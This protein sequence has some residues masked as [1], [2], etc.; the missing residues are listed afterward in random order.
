MG[1][2]ATVDRVTAVIA[3]TLS[4][5]MPF[6]AMQFLPAAQRKSPY[7]AEALYRAMRNLS[8]A[9]L[10]LATISC[11]SITALAPQLWG[12]ALVP[13]QGA[14]I[15][16]FAALPVLGLVPFLTNAFAG[17]TGH[18]SS[19]R[20]TLAHG[21]VFVFAAIAAAGV[22]RCRLLRNLCAVR[23][24]ADHRV[25][26]EA[27]RPGRG[28]GCSPSVR[29]LVSR[30]KLPKDVWQFALWARHRSLSPRPTRPGMSNIQL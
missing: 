30:F 1:V 6:A 4:M 3:Q 20:F 7:Q 8:V 17:T 13:Y 11:V 14:L 10:A 18:L 12:R 22:R 19:M 27:A 24:G 15:L 2:I 26:G 9:L 29:S 23:H 28:R 5:S 16:A 21:V 25:N